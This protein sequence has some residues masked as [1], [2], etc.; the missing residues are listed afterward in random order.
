MQAILA[1]GRL[2]MTMKLNVNFSFLHQIKLILNVEK[3][4]FITF[5]NYYDSVPETIEVMI[6]GNQLI[7]VQS[8]KYLGVTYDFNMEWYVHIKNIV[9]KTKYLIDLN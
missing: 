6:N 4:V 7:R 3:T 1:S 5:E 2:L 8:C 9:S